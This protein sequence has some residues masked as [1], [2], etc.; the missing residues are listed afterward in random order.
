MLYLAEDIG[1]PS[2]GELRLLSSR[3]IEAATL[4]NVGLAS[5]ESCTGGMVSAV[6][7]SIPGSSSTFLGGVTSYAI[8]IK[9]SLLGVSKDVLEDV[10][11]GAVSEECAQQMAAGARRVMSADL[12]VSTT[13]IAGPSGAE[14]GK[15]VGTVVFGLSVEEGERSVAHLLSGDR[16]EVRSKACLIALG[17]LYEELEGMRAAL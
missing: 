17:L 14:P 9:H 16:D 4:L 6:L 13:G 1:L 8:R 3:V 15:P 7:T 11:K 2:D 12:A 5:A 10:S